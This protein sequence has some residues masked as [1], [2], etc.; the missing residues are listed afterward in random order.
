LYS[1]VALAGANRRAKAAPTDEDGV[2]TAEEVASLDLSAAELVVLSAC[3]SGLGTVVDGEGVF[4]LRRAFEVAGARRLVL[5]LWRVR[6]DDAQFWMRAFY[7]AQG[8][9]SG[10]VAAGAASLHLLRAR[11]AA[12][13][14]SDPRHG[15]IHRQ[16]RTQLNSV[17]GSARRV[18][19][20]VRSNGSCTSAAVVGRKRSR[21]T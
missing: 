11:R 13:F 1:G 4:G 18:E 6:D 21:S 20:E 15:G 8:R 7:E 5:S 10:D 17:S 2:L 9:T 3:E 16:R 14:A 12:G 19:L